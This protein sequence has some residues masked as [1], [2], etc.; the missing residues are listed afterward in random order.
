MKSATVKTV[1]QRIK[2]RVVSVHELIPGGSHMCLPMPEGCGPMAILLN[3]G[4]G[5]RPWLRA[6]EKEMIEA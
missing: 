3:D 1:S 6:C 5:Q 4:E 2:E